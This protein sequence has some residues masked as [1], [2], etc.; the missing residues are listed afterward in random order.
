[1]QEI[2]GQTGIAVRDQRSRPAEGPVR[3]LLTQAT[4]W[5]ALDAVARAFDA[6]IG[7]YGPER[8]PV[9][10]D[11][12]F[13]DMPVSYHGPFRVAVKRLV[14]V[15][16]LEADAHFLM[17]HL[18]IAWEPTI[19]AFFLET[20]PTTLTV[21]GADGRPIPL[22]E[23]GRGLASVSGKLAERIELRLPGL[24]RAATAVGQLKGSF[25][26]V[27]AQK[28]LT[29]TFDK[30]APGQELVQE[31]IH[32][33][34]IEF[35]P[36]DGTLAVGLRLTYPEGGPR[37]ESFQ[38][39]LGHNEIFLEKGGRRFPSN[40]GSRIDHDGRRAEVHYFFED[41]P[42]RGFVI[43][44]ARDWKVVYRTPGRIEFLS[45]PFAFHNLP[46]P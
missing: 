23:G 24:P 36:D 19:Q 32:A 46:L 31:G 33:R 21:I 29:F 5:Q 3:L 16:D 39:W 4:F 17:V 6:N 35:Q 44:K 12:P 45:I 13:R 2:R 8:Q 42:G 40:G 43:G 7:L 34:L 14:A 11:G 26:L 20:R 37:F 30:P 15:R 10:T 18:E 25:S 38:S 9:L 1:M 41:D 22:S 28:M 27:A